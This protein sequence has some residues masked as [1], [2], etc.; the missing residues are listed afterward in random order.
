MTKAIDSSLLRGLTP[1]HI[2]ASTPT[3]KHLADDGF[4]AAMDGSLPR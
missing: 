2:G 4:M 3:L 1:R